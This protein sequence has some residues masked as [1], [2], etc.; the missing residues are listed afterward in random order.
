MTIGS[1]WSGGAVFFNGNEFQVFR[2]CPLCKGT[3]QNPPLQAI[4]DFLPRVLCKNAL[5]REGMEPHMFKNLDEL[6]NYVDSLR[7]PAVHG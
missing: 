4:E 1:K 5:C 7:T 3:R 2:L 6:A